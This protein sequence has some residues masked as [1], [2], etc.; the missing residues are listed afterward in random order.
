MAVMRERLE[1]IL[2]PV[3][4]SLGYELVLLEYSPSPKNA[5]LRLYIDA[6]AGITLEDCE[7]VSKEVSGVMDVEDP[8][9]SAYRL[10]VSSPGLD[11]PLVKPAHFARFTGHQARIQLLA[12][13]DGRRR[14]VGFIRGADE[15]RIKLETA[16][17]MFELPLSDIERARLVPDY[18]QE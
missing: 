4:V 9:R 17:G 15:S 10:E 1:Q 5:M 11:R 7:R 13:K 16:E 6:P 8:I 12:P 18:D 2:E 14:F 3:V